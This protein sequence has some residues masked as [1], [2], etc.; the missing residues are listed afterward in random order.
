MGLGAMSAATAGISIKMLANATV[1]WGAHECR[2]IFSRPGEVVLDGAVVATDY[3]IVFKTSDLPAI[4]RQQ[5]I[6]LTPDSTMQPQDF[7]T[8][9][10]KAR[11]DGALSDMVLTPA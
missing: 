3:G 2:A 4:V 6:T 8:R 9:T 1:V 11:D 7:L 10:P 5:T